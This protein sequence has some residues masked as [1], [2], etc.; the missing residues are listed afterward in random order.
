[1]SKLLF[2]IC[3]L[4]VAQVNLGRNVDNI[5]EKV[6]APNFAPLSD[7]KALEIGDA[8]HEGIVSEQNRKEKRRRH[9]VRGFDEDDVLIQYMCGKK[10]DE[11][12]AAI[13]S[14]L[15]AD[16]HRIHREE[17][18]V[19]QIKPNVGTVEAIINWTFGLVYACIGLYVLKFFLKWFIAE[20]L[21]FLRRGSRRLKEIRS[22]LPSIKAL[23]ENRR[24]RRAESDFLT[25]KNLYEN[26]LITEEM[27]MAR[28]SALKAVLGE[29]NNRQIGD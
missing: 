29:N 24:L 22:W 18:F 8:A 19:S 25:L 3:L 17:F 27:F 11:L 16:G 5:A 20:I 14:D 6:F 13:A 4:V 1:M 28:K 12:K 26:G 21:P 10:Q 7:Q 15:I 2:V 9:C 23:S